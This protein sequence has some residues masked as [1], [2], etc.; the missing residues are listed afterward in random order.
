MTKFQYRAVDPK[1]AEVIGQIAAD[2]VEAAERL[3]RKKRLAVLKLEQAAGLAQVPGKIETSNRTGP[4]QLFTQKLSAKQQ[5]LFTRQLAT[6]VSVM[7]LEEALNTL[8][9]QSES[10]VQ[11]SILG[12]VHNRVIEGYKLSGALAAEPKS[13]SALYVSMVA[14]GES[15]GALTRV[16]NNLADL[17][18][19]QAE[20]RSKLTAA[21]AYPAALALVA[22]A[23][24]IAMMTLVVPRLVEQFD[25]I[26]Q[27]LPFLTRAVIAASDF[28]VSYGWL[29]AGLIALCGFGFFRA[30]QNEG[31]RTKVDT[32]LLKL[33]L[34]GNIL[35]RTAAARLAR[36]LSVMLE[37]G[38]PLVDGLA[39]TTKTVGNRRIRAAYMD[40]MVAIKEGSTISAALKRTQICPPI[41][42]HMA[43]SGEQ[44]GKLAELLARAAESLER[45]FD[46]ASATILGLLEPAIIVIMGGV[47]T[48]IVMAILLPI[49]QLNVLAIG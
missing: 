38:M 9:E 48:L 33:P 40:V 35:T 20:V 39:A 27:T 15:S 25:T 49:L 17:A 21:L 29:L 44:S 41:L 16:L 37:S 18:D 8:V 36:T 26:G 12:R 13:F 28:L 32:L 34:V 23:V 45:E 24:V 6:L 14:A 4:F 3:L 42:V 1:G 7:P 10:D 46:S 19:R 22:F 30:L 5:G 47:V 11:R 31:V 2:T 43:A